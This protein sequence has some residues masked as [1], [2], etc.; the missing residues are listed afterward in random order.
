MK[1][2]TLIATLFYCHSLYGQEVFSSLVSNPILHTKKISFKKNKSPIILP[3]FDDFSSDELVV[4][5]DLWE[6]SSVF[7]NSDYP[8]NPVTIG[9]ATFDGLDENGYARNFSQ[10]NPSAP[11]DT[12]SSQSIDLSSVDSA[13]FMFYF[14]A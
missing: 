11:S 3:F 7:V 12:L 9:V 8:I 5:S 14:L 13:Y 6:I 4:N 2:F 1:I 10:I